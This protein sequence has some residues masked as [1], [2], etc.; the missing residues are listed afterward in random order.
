MPLVGS[1]FKVLVGHP[2]CT[3][4]CPCVH[5]PG[6]GRAGQILSVRVDLFAGNKTQIKKIF[7]ARFAVTS[8]LFPDMALP[9]GT[10]KD[11]DLQFN[12]YT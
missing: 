10:A 7:W 8:I 2:D 6:S 11:Y 4:K 5:E 9:K 12:G 3:K 1:R